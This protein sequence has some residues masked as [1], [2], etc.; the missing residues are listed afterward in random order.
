MR[1][2]SCCVAAAAILSIVNP[3]HWRSTPSSSAPSHT[4]GPTGR[5]P[6]CSHKQVKTRLEHQSKQPPVNHPTN[7]PKT[8]ARPRSVLQLALAKAHVQG[9]QHPV[10]RLPCPTSLQREVLGRREDLAIVIMDQS[11][12][13]YFK[14]MGGQTIPVGIPR[15]S[16]KMRTQSS[17]TTTTTKQH[18]DDSHSIRAASPWLAHPPC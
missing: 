9:A 18:H 6:P 4:T 2:L 11:R 10:H 8:F 3:L 1:K 14:L 15:C 16:A 17:S 7:N 13:V 5:S 12:M